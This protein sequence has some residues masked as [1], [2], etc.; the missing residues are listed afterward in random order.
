MTLIRYQFSSLWYK[1][2]KSVCIYLIY[3]AAESNF[4]DFDKVKKSWTIPRQK[5]QKALLESQTVHRTQIP[6][7][8]H[9]FIHSLIAVHDHIINAA[10]NH[11]NQ[12]LTIMIFILY[13]LSW[14][15]SFSIWPLNIE[16]I[17]TVGL[18]LYKCSLSLS[19]LLCLSVFDMEM[20]FPC[21]LWHDN[22]SIGG[23]TKNIIFSFVNDFVSL[24]LC[25]LLFF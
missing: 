23:I 2:T 22:I 25:S 8:I 6:A 12:L 5:T 11:T 3:T 1:K 17:M 14:L 13:L 19:L 9:S 15:F 18:C 7:V 10:R 4:N 24:I 16:I 20:H 21:P